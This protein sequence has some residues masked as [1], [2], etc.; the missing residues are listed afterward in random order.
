[1]N[2]HEFVNLLRNTTETS[3]K[4][5]AQLHQNI[6]RSVRLAGSMDRAPR[7]AWAGPA[8]GATMAVLV[9][10]FLHFST[11]PGLKSQ[12]PSV[13]Q[14]IDPSVTFEAF[15]VSLENLKDGSLLTENELELEI[16]RLKSDLKRFDFRS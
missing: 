14:K 12:Q 7:F 5:D 9:V 8:L 10:A 3:V 6:M 13:A 16:E 4:V 2:K 11:V 1:M 15:G